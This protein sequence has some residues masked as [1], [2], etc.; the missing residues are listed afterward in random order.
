V[1][2]DHCPRK[3]LIKNVTTLPKK[4]LKVKGAG[5][6]AQVAEYMLIKAKFKPQFLQKHCNHKLDSSLLKDPI[7]SNN[8]ESNK[9][10]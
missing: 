10:L 6:V 2:E 5:G 9:S 8:S 3:S 1:I 4:Q 7:L